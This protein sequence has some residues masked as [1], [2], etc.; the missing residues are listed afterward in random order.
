[1]KY[2]LLICTLILGYFTVDALYY[3]GPE[4]IMS[5][6]EIADV[7]EKPSKESEE[8]KR[9][10]GEVMEQDRRVA[11]FD[12]GRESDPFIE[13]QN[14][15]N[16]NSEDTASY[17]QGTLFDETIDP[18]IRANLFDEYISQEQ[19]REK[20][21]NVSRNVLENTNHTEL[22]TRALSLQAKHIP[23]DEYKEYLDELMLRIQNPK[24]K[25][26]LVN[27]RSGL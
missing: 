5:D 7:L 25:E 14:H 23:T 6:E 20:L 21:L 22:F 10:L 1:M 26:I 24:R 27:F 17:V 11:S 9:S 19:D 18:Q 13:M 8:L 12:D 2:F 4:T 3:K 16:E 15:F